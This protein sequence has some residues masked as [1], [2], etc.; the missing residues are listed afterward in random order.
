MRIGFFS[1]AMLVLYLAFV[2]PESAE[3]VL[4]RVRAFMRKRKSPALA[5]P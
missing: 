4:A 1:A 2:P 5:A 3:R